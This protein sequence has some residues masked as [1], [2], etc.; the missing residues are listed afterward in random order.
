[1]SMFTRKRKR[2]SL[3]ERR[4]RLKQATEAA[5]ASPF[6]KHFQLDQY[7][8]KLLSRVP[9]TPLSKMRKDLQRK[10]K[11]RR[12]AIKSIDPNKGIDI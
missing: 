11:K 8:E 9:E 2:L 3:A 5:K 7:R 4:K 1:M 6:E 10:A 12:E